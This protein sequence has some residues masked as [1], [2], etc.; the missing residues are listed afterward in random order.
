MKSNSRSLNSS[1]WRLSGGLRISDHPEHKGLLAGAITLD[2]LP[3]PRESDDLAV[4]QDHHRQPRCGRVEAG[5]LRR[6]G[7]GDLFVD[8]LRVDPTLERRDALF[9][10]LLG[11]ALRRDTLA[12][13]LR[14][15]V[16]RQDF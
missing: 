3:P 11:L 6:L 8:R 2:Y 4:P 15:G 5:P 14:C 13:G 12:L 1:S 9:A 10:N 16:R 7:I